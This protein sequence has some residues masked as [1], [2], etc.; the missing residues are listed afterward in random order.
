MSKQ[1][2]RRRAQLFDV[3]AHGRRQPRWPAATQI[4]EGLLPRGRQE[5][6]FVVVVGGEYIEPQHDIGLVQV[7]GRLEGIAVYLNGLHQLLRRKV[8]GEGIGQAQRGSQLG[9][10][11][12]GAQRSE[13]R[14]VGKECVSTCR[15]RWSPDP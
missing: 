13:E 10:E 6:R 2:L 3:V 5:M 7:S 1:V 11:Q 8:R 12:A 9:A 4:N 14:R 15:S